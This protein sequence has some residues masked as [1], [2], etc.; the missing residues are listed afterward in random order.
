MRLYIEALGLATPLGRGK[1]AVAEALFAGSRHGLVWRDEF[2]PGRRVRVGVVEGELPDVPKRLRAYACRNNRLALAALD[3]IARAIAGA[4]A[5]FGPSRIGVV[6]GTS[7]S[8]I[9]DGEL[10]LRARAGDGDWPSGFDYRQQE[11]GNAAVFAAAYLGLDGPAYTV[12]TACSSSAKVF[13]S[14]QRLVDAGLCD[15]VIVGG[16][17]TLCRLTLRG[18]DSLEALAADQCNPFSRNRDG[19]VIGEGAA[20]FLLTPRPA[21]IALLGVGESSDAH[22]VSAPDPTGMGAIRAMRG[23]LEAAGLPAEAVDYVNLHGTA[24]PLN[25]AMEGRAVAEVFGAATA[26]SSTKA[27]TDICSEPRA[28]SR[29]LSCG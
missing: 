17:D 8:G 19:I 6:L 29:R 4:I 26:C 10:A 3:E 27:L 24:T 16:V 28:R 5:V 25:D 11:A 14:A 1:A 22:H 18:F 15:A 23:A 21:D 13:A 2:L 9:A 20:M 7:T 12:V